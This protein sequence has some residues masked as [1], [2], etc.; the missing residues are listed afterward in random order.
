MVPTQKLR[1]KK[2]T[3]GPS[4]QGS[5]PSFLIVARVR[6]PFGVKGELL[7]D[8][9]TEFPG[10]LSQS[11][12]IYAGENR[13]P[14]RIES[15]RRHGGD[16]LLR[17]D[18]IRDR[19]AAEGLRGQALSVRVDDLPPLPAG[20]YYHHQIEGLEV[21]TERGEKLGTVK[22]ILKTGAN[23]VYVVEG[24][25]GEILLPAVRQ[26]ILEVRPE[27]GRMVV[28]LMEGLA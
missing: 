25:R 15:I 7:L 27:E 2:N 20:R 4:P 21:F 12:R 11:E 6:R 13:R 8:M 3:E 18:G 16:M 5:G 14:C 19:D 24:E 9:L 10:R 23:D 28:R 17:L 1:S 26:V 22:E